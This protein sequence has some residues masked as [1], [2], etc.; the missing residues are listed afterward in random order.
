M[1]EATVARP[2]AKMIKM[3]ERMM[4]RT[5]LFLGYSQQRPSSRLYPLRRESR[6]SCQ[7]W[8]QRKPEWRRFDVPVMQ[9]RSYS[10]AGA[11]LGL[12][13]RQVTIVFYKYV[14]GHQ[15]STVL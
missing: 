8:L 3:A 11:G 9:Q 15:C 7:Q 13:N 4:R 5:T 2:A 12:A 14:S 10:G 6:H 1:T